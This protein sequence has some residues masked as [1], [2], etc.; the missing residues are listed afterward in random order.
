MKRRSMPK[1]RRNKNTYGPKKAS[2]NMMYGPAKTT[3]PYPQFKPGN[4]HIY[5]GCDYPTVYNRCVGGRHI[6][7]IDRR[8]SWNQTMGDWA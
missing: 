2:G 6:D 1:V 4:F 3:P 5:C 7:P 8:G